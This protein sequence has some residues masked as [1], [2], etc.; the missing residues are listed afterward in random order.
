MS[1]I[2]AIGGPRGVVTTHLCI[3]LLI[4]NILMLVFVDKN[5]VHLSQVRPPAHVP[6]PKI[7]IFHFVNSFPLQGFCTTFGIMTHYFFLAAFFWMGFEGYV[8]YKVIIVVFDDGKDR[9]TMQYIVAY[10]GPGLIV[11]VTGLT[12][13]WFRDDAYESDM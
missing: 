11:L 2:P 3:C 8:L 9:F 1:S 4:G 6:L 5:Y 13:I 12:A 10:G 7:L